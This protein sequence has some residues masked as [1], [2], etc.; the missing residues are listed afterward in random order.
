MKKCKLVLLVS[1]LSATLLTGCDDIEASFNEFLISK[2]TV[3]ET[4]N[5][6]D[7]LDYPDNV[8]V[9]YTYTNKYVTDQEYDSMYF[10]TE[11]VSLHTFKFTFDN[12][13]KEKTISCSIDVVP[14]KPKVVSNSNAIYVIKDQTLSFENLFNRSGIDALPFGNVDVKFKGVTF[15]ADYE[16]NNVKL[17]NEAIET[18]YRSFSN[19]S[20][21]TFDKFGKYIFDIEIF[22]SE[23]S[24]TTTMQVSVFD[25]YGETLN[26]YSFDGL[27]KGESN[28]A[29]LVK[30][31]TTNKLSYLI[32]ED[33]VT[34]SLDK[35]Y[36]IECEFVGKQAPQL[37]LGSDS[38]NGKKYDG[39]G[40]VISLEEDSKNQFGIYGYDKLNSA[41]LS[42]SRSEGYTFSRKTLVNGQ[43]Y[44]WQTIFRVT[45]SGGEKKLAIMSY[46]YKGSSL[47]RTY[48]WASVSANEFLDDSYFGYLGSSV[49]DALF[50]YSP[51]QV[52]NL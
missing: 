32:Y 39:K 2:I 33:S 5:F 22:N 19:E 23:G 8:N 41:N 4:I 24:V 44:K 40:F 31:N 34:L 36:T 35:K 26:G 6:N 50:T 51:L 7:Y 9:S 16:P 29:L 45:N 28:T 27:I 14:E 18:N 38:I 49:D 13:N 43:R 37:I 15:S 42:P 52:E 46:L 3:G 12:G 20:E 47:F 21:F 1:C 30:S 25:S 17:S 11:T 48:S 10:I